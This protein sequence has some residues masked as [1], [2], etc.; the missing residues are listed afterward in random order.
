MAGEVVMR[1]EATP[2]KPGAAN[3]KVVVSNVV[4]AGP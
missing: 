1:R 3:V 4:K 2:V